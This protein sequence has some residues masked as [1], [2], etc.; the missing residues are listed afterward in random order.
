MSEQQRTA[1]RSSLSAHFWSS[2][3]HLRL[4]LP[5]DTSWHTDAVVLVHASS[6][7]VV[8]PAQRGLTVQPASTS[9][10]LQRRP[11]TEAQKASASGNVLPLLLQLSMPMP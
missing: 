2:T 1:C 9:N 6:G 10:L 8:L 3:E 7:R 11:P 5:Q 4:G